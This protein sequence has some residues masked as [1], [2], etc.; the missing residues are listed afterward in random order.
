[1][2][3]SLD[4]PSLG[5]STPRPIINNG[6]SLVLTA[7]SVNE[8]GSANWFSNSQ[9]FI[10]ALSTLGK[11]SVVD[12]ETQNTVNNVPVAF[13]V[14]RLNSYLA[15][16]T[17]SLYSPGSTAAA[18][19]SSAGLTPGAIE[20]GLNVSLLPSVQSDGRRILMQMGLSDTVLDS[21]GTAQS[22]GE[23]IQL[24]NTSGRESV[25]RTWLRSG[26]SY[27]VAGYQ[28]L[29]TSATT[30]TPF[31]KTTWLAGGNRDITNAKDVLVVVVTP[32]ASAYDA[33]L[34]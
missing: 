18:T 8:N 3:Q 6:S 20:T 23:A 16:T 10:D 4:E 24:P 19:G 17:P 15:Q 1:M 2:Q 12:D 30:N 27:V 13:K 33:T 22:G 14:F 26:Q 5:L 29:Q 32:V 34:H 7:P 9:F 11:V 25:M 28:N 31:T 21:F